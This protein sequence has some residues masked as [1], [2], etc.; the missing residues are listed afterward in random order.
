MTPETTLPTEPLGSIPRPPALVQAI[1]DADAGRFDPAELEALYDD[2][3]R[4]TLRRFEATG[5]PVVSDGEQRKNHNF[6]DCAVHGRPNFAPDG[7][8]LRFVSHTRQWP[9]LTAGPS[10]YRQRG[11]QYLARA[12]QHSLIKPGQRVYVGVIDVL[13]P[14]IETP[15]QVRERVLE[16]ARCIRPEQLGT[17]DDCGFCPFCDDG[18]TSRNTAFAKI[19]ARVEGT[20]LASAVLGR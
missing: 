5:S 20:A 19:A 15:Q 13:D 10:R 1:R 7:F 18:S 12:Q 11:D 9:R 4:D 14:P 8:K 2:A 6:A 17:T 3:V 16:A